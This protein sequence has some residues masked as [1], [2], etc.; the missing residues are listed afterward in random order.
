MRLRPLLPSELSAEQ[1]AV[2]DGIVHGSRGNRPGIR[3]LA[4]DGSLRGPF[5]AMLRNPRVGARLEA[6]GAALRFETDL[7]PDLREFTIL[8]A[9]TQWRCAFEWFEHEPIARN[10]GVP[11]GVLDAVARGAVCA[12]VDENYAVIEKAAREFF[13]CGRVSDE[14]FD[15]LR[16][17]LGEEQVF[18]VLALLGYY[19]TLALLLNVFGTS[20]EPVPDGTTVPLWAEHRSDSERQAS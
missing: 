3:L 17:R 6:I 11:S 2:Y 14:A 8:L 19:S 13:A 16:A 4:D 1:R 12:D 15:R 7:R 20:E 5:D 9:A 18:E 10:A